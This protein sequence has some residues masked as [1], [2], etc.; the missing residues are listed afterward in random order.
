MRAIIAGGGPAGL[1]SAKWLNDRGYEVIVLEKRAV[2]GGKVSSWRDA[3]G[4]WV[5]S[6]LHVFFVKFRHRVQHH[7][8]RAG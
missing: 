2:S 8:Q 7:R 4:D 3:D 5:E 6:G 1:A